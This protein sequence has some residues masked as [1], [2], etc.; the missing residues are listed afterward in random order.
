MRLDASSSSCF[1]FK[2]KWLTAQ[3]EC[4]K[5]G[6]SLVSLETPEENECVM[7]IINKNGSASATP[8]NKNY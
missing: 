2:M 6:M 3:D 7:S 1:I 4:S 5:K 8:C